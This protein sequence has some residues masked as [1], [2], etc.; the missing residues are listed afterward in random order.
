MNDRRVAVVI[1]SVERKSQPIFCTSTFRRPGGKFMAVVTSTFSGVIDLSLLQ[2]KNCNDVSTEVA[3][4]NFI[5]VRTDA[6]H[7]IGYSC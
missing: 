3:V 5:P 2:H 6:E 7:T 4:T 1:G